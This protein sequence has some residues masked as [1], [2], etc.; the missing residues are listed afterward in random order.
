MKRRTFLQYSTYATTATVAT[1]AGLTHT[2][3]PGYAAPVT[4]NG[5]V[6]PALVIGSGYGGA[7][8]ALRLTQAGIETTVVEMGKL[9]DRPEDPH[10]M[11]FCNMRGPDERSFWFKDRT[12]MPF[13]TLL[14][15]DVI[16]RDIGRGPG[17]L[18][19][20]YFDNIAVYL[21][22]A[23]GGGSVVN[24]GMAPT[25]DR[26]FLAEKLPA[27]VVNDLYATYF[28][29]ASAELG[30]SSPPD[31]ILNSSWYQFSQVA[32]GNAR[33]AGYRVDTIP[34]VYDWDYMRRE[35][36]GTAVQSAMTGQ[37]IFGNDCGKKSLDKTYLARANA[38]GHLRL[39]SLTQVTGI[40]WDG[41]TY[42]VTIETH[43]SQWNLLD[44]KTLRTT[45]LFVAAGVLGTV[46]LLLKAR[47]A[48]GL[49]NL[50]DD[51]GKGFGQN[52]N[53]MIARSSWVATGANQS[54]IPAQAINNWGDPNAQVL[55]ELA[56]MPAGLELFMTNYLAIG[57]TEQRATFGL[58][59]NN[60]LTLDWRSD[61]ADESANKVYSL[62]N[63]INAANATIYRYDLFGTGQPLTSAFTYHPLGGAI[64]GAVTDEFGRVKGHDGLYIMDGSLLPGQVGVNPFLT[65][66]AIAERNIE[67][68]LARDF[69]EVPAHLPTPYQSFRLRD[70]ESQSY[71]APAG[72]E[73]GASLVL[74]TDPNTSARFV[75]QPD[76]SGHALRSA[77]TGLVVTLGGGDA[78]SD[79][80]TASLQPDAPTLS[81]RFAIR[82]EG[83]GRSLRLAADGTFLAGR[84]AGQP[85]GTAATPSV[86]TL[87]DRLIVDS[88]E[89]PAGAM[90]VGAT[91]NLENAA[92]G[93]TL[94]VLG[95]FSSEGAEIQTWRAEADDAS[96]F[97]VQ[98][99]GGLVRFVNRRS[100]LAVAAVSGE[101][102]AGVV[103]RPVSDADPNQLFV[104]LGSAEG[105]YL[106][107]DPSQSRALTALRGAMQLTMNSLQGL[108]G[109]RWK[110]TNIAGGSYSVNY[111]LPEIGKTYRITNKGNGLAFD[112][113]NRNG[114]DWSHIVTAN[115]EPG[116]PW[117][118]WEV[119]PCNEGLAFVN[120][121]SGKAMDLQ[122]G[123]IFNGT[124]FVL[125]PY[126]SGHNQQFAIEG[127]P[128]EQGY[129]IR[130]HASTRYVDVTG[131]NTSWLAQFDRNESNPFQ[132]WYFEETP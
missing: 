106:F 88:A 103:Q 97:E 124:N 30:V 128:G 56:P 48:G 94:N 8:S 125:W 113:E 45:R 78:A 49:A 132:H 6:L 64:L 42:Q 32:A 84:G 112:V 95:G 108:P 20:V 98:Q 102:G 86:W 33:T 116:S 90:P 126:A 110:F 54:T 68:I 104:P 16:N 17:P 91:V 37:V 119:K 19:K 109:Q 57:R 4:D 29:K 51:L 130:V 92:T 62:F 34:N 67:N 28:A 21:G 22:R 13:T 127:Q 46:E 93:L 96:L 47:K 53:H 14:G 72:G 1:V 105:G 85:V 52:G 39:L 74:S 27:S 79:T 122:G 2:Q 26:G 123:I 73:P 87:D 114:N 11:V 89:A 83:A 69:A 44:T 50:S 43:D 15:L 55:A 66:T 118:K 60:A 65:I 77:D 107:A 58:N 63:A 129:L 10:S 117:Q 61:Q 80:R 82:T 99:V 70:A 3:A 23:V 71:L 35:I 115:V 25:P 121:A 7:V 5:R 101:D 18:D 120:V 24:G 131:G 100:H 12:D 81:Q 9:W 111:V 75:A 31:D 59:E 76:D 41:E 36:A 38:T 40:A